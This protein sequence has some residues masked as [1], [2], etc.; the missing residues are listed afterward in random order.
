V[1]LN[2]EIAVFAAS[3][4]AFGSSA[5]GEA[6]R[7]SDRDFLIV[8][9]DVRVLRARTVTLK[10]QGFSVASY[11]FRKL[12]WLASRGA[13]FIQ[14]LR[15]EAAITI[16]RGDRLARLLASFRPK[17]VYDEELKANARLASLVDTVPVGA[18][19]ELW[20]ADVLYV[21]VRNFGVLWLASRGKY[22]FAYDRILESLQSAGVLR[23]DSVLHLRQLRFLKSLYRGDHAASGGVVLAKILGAHAGL[24]PEYFPAALRI[25]P[26][27]EVL[28]APPPEAGSAAYLVLRDL[29]KRML[30]ARSISGERLGDAALDAL[31]GWIR[32][33]RVYANLS[34]V[35]APRLRMKLASYVHQN[36]ETFVA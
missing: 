24:P 34:A 28:L 22:V 9:D 12:D 8:D 33:P 11:T 30:A 32:D 4:A 5:R 25:V 2:N 17:E 20:A 36:R 1:K 35:Q 16:D 6:D 18:V 31:A 3:E 29:E 14:H 19:S 7:L 26:V 21:T 13:L 10:A 23:P 15:L 27:N